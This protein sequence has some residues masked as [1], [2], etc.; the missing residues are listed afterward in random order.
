L[1]QMSVRG[2]AA[3]D[4]AGNG[5][6]ARQL[7]EAAEQFRDIRLTRIVDLDHITEDVLRTITG[8]DMAEAIAS[9]HRRLDMAA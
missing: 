4:I 3:L 8:D 9:V 7:V 2:K 6:Y 1:S 5:R